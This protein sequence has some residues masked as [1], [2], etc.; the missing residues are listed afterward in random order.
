MQLKLPH[1]VFVVVL[2]AIIILITNLWTFSAK[3]LI[4]FN[5]S[6]SFINGPLD[7]S[8]HF[9]YSL[10]VIIALISLILLLILFYLW[11]RKDEGT[12]IQPFIVGCCDNNYSGN[13]ISDLLTA[14]LIRIRNIHEAAR[15]VKVEATGLPKTK[16]VIHK[17]KTVIHKAKMLSII[18]S[19]NLIRGFF[20]LLGTSLK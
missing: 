17:A 10:L 9:L 13:A 12:F 7:N 6:L 4:G 16:T 11:L 1:K 18:S 5:E 20:L 2:L 3:I 19:S 14:E 15:A 8:K